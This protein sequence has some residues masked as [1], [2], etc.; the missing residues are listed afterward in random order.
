[1][2]GDTFARSLRFREPGYFIGLQAKDRPFIQWPGPKFTIELNGWFVPIQ[3][4]PFHPPAA[5][6]ARNL[7]QMNKQ[8][9]AVAFAAQLW[10]HEEIFKVKPWPAQP[11]GKIVKEN[12][13][14][15]RRFLFEPE[16]NFCA[17]FLSEQ[18]LAQLLLGRT[19]I[20]RRAFVSGEILNKREDQRDIGLDGVADLEILARG[21]H[22]MVMFSTVRRPHLRSALKYKHRRRPVDR[23]IA[24]QAVV[25]MPIRPNIDGPDGVITTG[26]IV[27]CPLDDR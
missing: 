23:P 25:S 13:E 8:G 18:D 14:A 24:R 2:R 19:H 7:C 5:T 17:S 20:V 27:S 6:I 11:G 26:T 4:R 16:Q 12:S 10:F 21:I 9:A 15:D 3:D 1:M 22:S